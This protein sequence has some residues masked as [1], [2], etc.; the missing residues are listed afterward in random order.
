MDFLNEP[1]RIYLQDKAGKTIA[2]VQFPAESAN[3]VNISHTFV[4]NS[5]RGQGIA[6]LLMKAAAEQLRHEHKK[7]RLT[8][9]YA[10]Q[11][12]SRHPE[13]DDIII[14]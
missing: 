8:C 4:D 7:A 10:V 5:L 11:W 3:T 2:E 1:G 13:Y 12:F 9:S 14:R 6:G